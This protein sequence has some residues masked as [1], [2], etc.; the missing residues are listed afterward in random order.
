MDSFTTSESTL[1]YLDS[2][3]DAAFAG[4]SC[5]RLSGGFGNFVWRVELKKRFRG[6]S[7][8]ILKHAKPFAATNNAVPLSLERME[9]EYNAL[10][11]F[12]DLTRLAHPI[13][14]GTTK[15]DANGGRTAY[16]SII[17]LPTVFHF[18]RENHVLIL[19]DAGDHPSLKS[20]L[21][22]SPPD[23]ART[24]TASEIGGQLGYFLAFLHR[25][26]KGNQTFKDLF[27]N[28]KMARQI[29][30]WRTAGR[31]EETA[32]NYYVT[33]QRVADAAALITKDTLESD[34]TFNMGD[35]WF[36]IYFDR[37]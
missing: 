27:S 13:D 35:F 3:N 32:S 14:R 10:T 1:K 19:E 28:H 30:A 7:T 15:Y 9:F 11:I 36:V 37:A 18:D 24:H 12:H 21:S 20:L 34:E 25:T 4:A 22:Q 23:P 29:C 26:G 6:H 8:V 2:L 31:L 16:S 33:D 17:R 5:A